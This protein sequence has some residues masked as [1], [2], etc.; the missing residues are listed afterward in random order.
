MG[1]RLQLDGNRGPITAALPPT[2]AA[3]DI[4]RVVAR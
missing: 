4:L 1:Y 3:D 2:L